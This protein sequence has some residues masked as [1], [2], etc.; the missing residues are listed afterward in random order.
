MPPIV[1]DGLK[2][3]HCHGRGT[4]SARTD[5]AA[6]YASKGLIYVAGVGLSGWAG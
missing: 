2:L 1:S 6:R 5:S 4:A 3:S